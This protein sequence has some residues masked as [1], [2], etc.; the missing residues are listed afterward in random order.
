[1]HHFV[2]LPQENQETPTP[3]DPQHTLAIKRWTREYL[4][5][6]ESA[7]VTVSEFACTDPGC[8][9]LESLISVF[10]EGGGTRVWKLTRP[11]MAVTKTMLQQT[12]AAPPVR[13]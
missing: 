1:V 6:P 5:L 10:E 9:L 12:L 2:A 11:K 7:V 4:K 13:Q 8:P 3:A